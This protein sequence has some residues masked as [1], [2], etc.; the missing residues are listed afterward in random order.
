MAPEGLTGT[1]CSC[2]LALRVAKPSQ[3]GACSVGLLAELL[4][5]ELNLCR[6]LGLIFGNLI[7]RLTW[8]AICWGRRKTEGTQSSLH[9]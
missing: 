5:R 8:T 4:L 2:L 3:R 7:P 9:Q 1:G 6:A